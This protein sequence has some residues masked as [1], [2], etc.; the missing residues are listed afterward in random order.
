MI[1][2]TECKILDAGKG[3][4][5]DRQVRKMIFDLRITIYKNRLL[6]S[7]FE[8]FYGRVS[9]IYAAAFMQYAQG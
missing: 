4:R 3:T 6:S 8:V 9:S 5:N 7:I 2:D 1:L